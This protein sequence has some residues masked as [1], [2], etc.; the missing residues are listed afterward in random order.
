MTEQLTWKIQEYTGP[1]E[2]DEW[3]SESGD[4][5]GV[6]LLTRHRAKQKSGYMRCGE[7]R[8]YCWKADQ[9]ID[10]RNKLSTN[11]AIIMTI[12]PIGKYKII[13]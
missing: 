10:P 2:G 7:R 13:M 4:F 8:D 9:E 12:I 3:G 5:R 1:T 11:K 6:W